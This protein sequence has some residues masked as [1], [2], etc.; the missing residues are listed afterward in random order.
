[1]SPYRVEQR[2]SGRWALYYHQYL[3]K[4][5]E[6]QATALDHANLLNEEVALLD[7]Q[8]AAWTRCY[9]GDGW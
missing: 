7:K 1:M 9:G 6:N 8:A 4:T 2:E 3:I 5:Y